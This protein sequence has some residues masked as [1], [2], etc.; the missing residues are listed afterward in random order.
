MPACKDAIEGIPVGIPARS[1]AN[2]CCFGIAATYSLKRHD[3]KREC[4]RFAGTVAA[5]NHT[6]QTVQSNR[7]KMRAQSLSSS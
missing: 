2:G 7:L 5:L 1:L 3:I 4:C 6:L